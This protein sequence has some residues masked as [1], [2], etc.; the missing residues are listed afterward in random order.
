MSRT[1]VFLLLALLWTAAAMAQDVVVRTSLDPSGRVMVG[2]EVR[3]FVDVLFPGEMPHPPR[4]AA[5]RIAGAQVFRFESQATNVRE[6]IG[7]A[8]HAGQRFEFEVYPRR[9]GTLAVPPVA[10]TLL[11]PAGDPAGTRQGSGLSMQAFVPRGL[12]PAGPIVV[13]RS[14]TLH[15]EWQPA[16]LGKLHVGD[17]LTRQV[18][19]TAAGVPGLALADL[20]FAAPEGIRTYADVPDIHDRIE[21]DEVTGTRTDRVT[22]LLERAGRFVIPA[23]SQPWWDLDGQSPRTLPLPARTVDVVAAPVPSRDQ[24]GRP[25]ILGVVAAMMA[26]VGIAIAVL[27]RHGITDAWAG[28]RGGPRHV[29]RAA[30]SRLH[31]QCR[32][33]DPA[34]TYQAWQNWHAICPVDTRCPAL[35]TAV[36]DLESCLFGGG[37]SWTA[38]DGRRLLRAVSAL[39]TRHRTATPRPILPPLN[40]DSATR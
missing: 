1:T 27:G 12:D 33:A 5:P 34:A 15:E 22:Y 14:V 21:R 23:A 10:V 3:L 29:E 37:A 38:L 19:R 7:G 17:A 8:D 6:R 24:P 20:T 32:G 40:P 2:Q 25:A 13:S 16:S 9:A 4:V 28:W 35:A 36:R 18:T 39:R 31:R 30:F 11:D 26:V